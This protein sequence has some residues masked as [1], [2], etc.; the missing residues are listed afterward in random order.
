MSYLSAKSKLIGEIFMTR[1]FNA[2]RTA[3]N[4]LF[5]NKEYIA[6]VNDFNKKKNAAKNNDET[7][8]EL[9][10]E[11]RKLAAIPEINAYFNAAGNMTNFIIA[12]MNDI[13]NAIENNLK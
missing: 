13:N 1:E 12:L 11:Y 7:K 10:A 8:A 9:E 6:K 4:R 5:E 3:K 2:L